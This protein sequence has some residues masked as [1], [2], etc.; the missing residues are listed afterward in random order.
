MGFDVRKIP[1]SVTFALVAAYNQLRLDNISTN[2]HLSRTERTNRPGYTNQSV[3]RVTVTNTGTDSATCIVLA[4][5][6]KSVYN[7][8][9]VG[10]VGVVHNTAVSAVLTT[11]TATDGPT[12]ITLANALKTAYNIHLTASNVHYT[13]DTTNATT[14]AASTDTATLVTLVTELKADLNAHMAFAPVG[15]FINLVPA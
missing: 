7:E 11:A 8:H 5:E 1:D 4:N 10:A 12:A 9:V 6:L 15:T 14:A 13:N 2:A 3:T